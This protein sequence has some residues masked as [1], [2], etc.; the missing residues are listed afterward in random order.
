MSDCINMEMALQQSHVE[1][2]NM[3]E[4]ELN[5]TDKE[6]EYYLVIANVN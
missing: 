3:S 6:D 5:S 1:S 2:F 4:V